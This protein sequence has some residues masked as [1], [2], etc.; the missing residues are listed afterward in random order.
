MFREETLARNALVYIVRP[1]LDSVKMMINQIKMQR[2]KRVPA[3]NNYMFFVPRRTIECDELLQN[4][5]L[6]LD[7]RIK[8]F[9]VDLIMLEEDVL[10][11]ELNNNFA[12]YCM[13]D[14][15]TYKV[16]VESSINRLE[17]VFGSIKYKIGKGPVSN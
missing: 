8:V 15:D 11:L 16:Y 10:S 7:E 2:E 1:D 17:T 4:E 3:T 5:D 13:Q 12:H 9:N 6:L 14:D